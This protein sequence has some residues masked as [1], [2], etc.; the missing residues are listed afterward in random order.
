MLKVNLSEMV[1]KNPVVPASGTFGYGYEMQRFYDV[2]QLG[3]IALKAI[4]VEKRFGNPL[5]RVCDTQGG[6]LNAIGLQNPGVELFLSEHYDK[7]NS[8]VDYPLIYNVSGSK[9]EDYVEVVRQLCMVV[10]TGIIELNVSCPN[11]TKGAMAFGSDVNTLSI[12]IKAVKEVSTLPVYVKLTPNVTNIVTI[13]KCCE[14]SG[15]DGLVMINTLVGMQIDI[16]KTDYMIA[17]KTGGLSGASIKPIAIKMI[18]DV[19]KNVSIPI[20]GCGGVTCAEDVVEMMMAGA[21]LVQV[22]TQNLIDPYACMT[23]I[24]DLEVLVPKLGYEKITDIIGAIHE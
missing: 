23:I 6:M 12:L 17:N 19:Y 22:G 4:T 7:I 15:A 8:L 3:S 24:K 9:I 10:K 13:A 11:V 16:Y 5:P 20:I 18:H 21:S 1:F 2:N 14:D